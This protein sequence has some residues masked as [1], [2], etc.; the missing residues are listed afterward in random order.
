MTLMSIILET[1]TEA[2]GIFDLGDPR[3]WVFFSL[4][5]LFAVVIWKK[6]PALVAK[7]LDER[8]DAIRAELDDARRLREEAQELLASYERRQREAEKEAEDIISQARHE[9]ELFAH[10]AREK[11]QDVLQRRAEAATRKIAQAEARAAADVRAQ[12]AA[13]ATSTAKFA[14]E[15][16]LGKTGQGKLINE[17]IDALG[18]TLQ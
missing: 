8:A 6:V 18:K 4:A 3:L 2:P 16:S 9:A 1:G 13:L 5:V 15:E 7:S 14:L 12:A 11:L 17:S 10:D